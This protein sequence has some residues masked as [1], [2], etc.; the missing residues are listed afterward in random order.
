MPPAAKKI[1][2]DVNITGA[3]C[4]AGSIPDVFLGDADD[5]GLSRT[6]SIRTKPGRGD[7]T[8]SLSCSDKLLKWSML[9]IQVG[10]ILDSL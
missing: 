7:R 2:L 8:L 5:D 3:K 9:G 6:G 1:K 4:V 10:V